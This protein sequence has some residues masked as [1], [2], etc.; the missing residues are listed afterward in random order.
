MKKWLMIIS[1][2]F[3]GCLLSQSLIAGQNRLIQI[4]PENIESDGWLAEDEPIIA[5]N[6]ETLSMIINGAANRYLELGV[7]KAVF[8]TYEKGDVYLI[9]EIYETDS[10]MDAKNVF[11]EFENNHS[12]PLQKIGSDSRF[13]SE[14]GSSYMVEYIQDRFYVR[15]SIT[16]KSEDAKV[17]ILTFAKSISDN[18][19][20]FNNP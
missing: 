13:T 12:K 9:L 14:M 15:L 3:L 8:I 17:S 1:G 2:I 10:E 6:E 18:I 7:K 11:G 20:K 19:L 4:L 16:Q 5:T